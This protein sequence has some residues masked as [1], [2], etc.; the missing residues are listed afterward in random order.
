VAELRSRT[1]L[2]VAYATLCLSETGWNMQKAMEAFQQSQ[3]SLP[4][5]AYE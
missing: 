5:D 3:G 4:P 2:N 1:R